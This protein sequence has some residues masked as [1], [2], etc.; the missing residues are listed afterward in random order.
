[1]G[2]PLFKKCAPCYF[3]AYEKLVYRNIIAE[4]TVFNFKL[5]NI[6][7]FCI[8]YHVSKVSQLNEGPIRK[9]SDIFLLIFYVL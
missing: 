9:I 3:Y 1:M 6:Y 2:D 8:G 4:N 7:L 5:L